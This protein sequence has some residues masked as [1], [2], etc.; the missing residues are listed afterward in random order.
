MTFGLVHATIKDTQL[1]S[2]CS[3]TCLGFLPMLYCKG[4]SVGLL[5]SRPPLRA[6]GKRGRAQHVS[7]IHS[8]D[9]SSKVT[10]CSNRLPE[11]QAVTDFLC[12]LLQ[13]D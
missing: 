7:V 10:Y 8:I 4:F 9:P 2:H 11:W 12:S 1:A 13:T 6:K 5:S 3:D